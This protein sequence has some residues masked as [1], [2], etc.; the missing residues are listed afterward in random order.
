[1]DAITI[2]L[3][4]KGT[5]TLPRALRRRYHLE[6]G[7]SFTLTD[8][9]DGSLLLTPRVSRVA[10]VGDQLAELLAQEHV[11]IDELLPALAQEREAYF[12]ERYAQP[13]PVSG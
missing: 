2:Q 10:Q 12:R 7:D 1:V 4:Q 8:L 9:G 11:E 3:R 13:P 5:I 6:P